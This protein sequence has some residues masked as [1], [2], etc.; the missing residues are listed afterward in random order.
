MAYKAVLKLIIIWRVKVHLFKLPILSSFLLNFV[1]LYLA[2]KT[3]EGPVLKTGPLH[4]SNS[5]YA[6]ATE[7]VQNN[8]YNNCH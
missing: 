3:S 7:N 2:L 6:C 5:N 8:F 1:S 4:P